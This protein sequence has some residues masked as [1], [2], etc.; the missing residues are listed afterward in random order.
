MI[1]K[2]GQRWGR[3][4]DVKTQ[5]QRDLGRPQL[6]WIPRSASNCC[7]QLWVLQERIRASLKVWQV[8]EAN[9]EPA[10]PVGGFLVNPSIFLPLFTVEWNY[11]VSITG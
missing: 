9:T 8:P 3:T 7:A 1:W 5:I 2:E 4:W 10:D 11:K 6:T